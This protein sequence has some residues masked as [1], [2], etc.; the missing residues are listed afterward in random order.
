MKEVYADTSYWIA[1]FARRDPWKE[2]ADRARHRIGDVRLVTVDEVLVEFLNAF[3]AAG[4]HLRTEAAGFVG[5]ILAHPGVETVPQS[6][7]SCLQGLELYKKRADKS[8]SLTDCI[9][10]TLMHARAIS[11]VLTTDQHFAQ[12]GFAVLM[13][14]HNRKSAR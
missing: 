10:M 14:R 4:K 6:R 11:R 3:S 2:A 5:D 9:S 13:Q 7:Q 12:E 8:Y 1:I